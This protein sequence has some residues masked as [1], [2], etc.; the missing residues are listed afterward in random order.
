MFSRNVVLGSVSR[1]GALAGAVVVPELDQDVVGLA[2]HRGGPESLGAEALGTAAI[3]GEVDYLHVF[4]EPG[5]EAG[6]PASLVIHGG[7]ADQDDAN[8]RARLSGGEARH[9]Q[10]EC[11][12]QL[13]THRGETI[14]TVVR[15]GAHVYDGTVELD[16]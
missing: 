11:G 2:G 12:K 9:E 10:Q 14:E 6:T 4:A 8:G 13:G 1:S 5:A 15:F 3:L 7:I 16:V